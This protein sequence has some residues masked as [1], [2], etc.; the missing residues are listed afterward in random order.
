MSYLKHL[1]PGL[2]SAGICIKPEND[3]Q[4]TTHRNALGHHLVWIIP[5]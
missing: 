4:L 2:Y 1:S 5:S 3:K